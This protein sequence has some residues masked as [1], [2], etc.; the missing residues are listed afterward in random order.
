MG[1]L[2]VHS[3]APA[4]ELTSSPWAQGGPEGCDSPSSDIMFVAEWSQSEIA[5]NSTPN[6]SEEQQQSSWGAS[7]WEEGLVNTTG[8]G[9]AESDGAAATDGLGSFPGHEE[10]SEMLDDGNNM[11]VDYISNLGS[12]CS[13]TPWEVISDLPTTPAA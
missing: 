12:E 9:G 8:P 2:R 6:R 1:G 7:E 13:F 11:L 5:T 4:E 10:E 3:S